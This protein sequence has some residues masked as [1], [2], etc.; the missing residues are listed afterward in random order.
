MA[1]PLYCTKKAWA[2]STFDTLVDEGSPEASILVCTPGRAVNPEDVV[3]FSNSADYFSEDAPAP[4]ETPAP[5][6]PAPGGPMVTLKPAIPPVPA[7][8][9]PVPAT[10]QP[11]A[12]VAPAP[13]AG[14]R[15]KRTPPV[16]PEIDG[17]A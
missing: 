9:V 13:D 4:R 16:N 6:V 12:D 1:K 17:K 7:P 10:A 14:S 3:G 11:P 5:E 8:E 15:A 2:N